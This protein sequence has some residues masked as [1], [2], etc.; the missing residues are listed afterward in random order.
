MD[1]GE[2]VTGR[3]VLRGRIGLGIA[4]AAGI[5][6]LAGCESS[7]EKA[8]KHYES[9]LALL[10][11]GDV[12]RAMVEFRNVFS[13]DGNHQEARQTYARLLREQGS[14]REA[15]SQYLRLVEQY[16]DNAE[17]NRALAEMAL[18][19]SNWDDADRYG[20]AALRL[21]PDEPEVQGIGAMIDY[22]AALMSRDEAAGQA[23]LQRAQALVGQ[24]PELVVA[25]RVTL[26]SLVRKSD[27]EAVLAS[28]DEGLQHDPNSFEFQRMRAAALFQLGRTDDLEAQLRQMAL[29]NPEDTEIENSLLGLFINQKRP[30]AAEEFLRSRV[31]PASADPAA[32]QRLVSFIAQTRGMPAARQEID[33][34]VAGNPPKVGIYRTMRAGIDFDAGNRDG[35]MAEMQSIIDSKPEPDVL[36]QARVTL[37]R[38]MAQ[39]GNKVGGRALVEEVLASTPSDVDALKLKGNWLIDDDRTGDA[40][41]ALRS[42]LEYAPRDPQ[43]MTLMARAHERDG[44]RDLMGEMLSQA[45]VAS[46]R[47]PSES[48]RYAAFLEQDGKHLPAEDALVNALRLQPR[49][50]DLL[51][52]LGRVYVA[53]KDWPRADHVVRTLKE[54]GTDQAV[55]SANEITANRLAALNQDQELAAFL[56][57][58][59]AEGDSGPG[60]ELALIRTSLLR[61]DT[62][63]ALRQADALL[64]KTPDNP[65]ALYLHAAVLLS[66]GQKEGLD[67][68]RALTQS[69]P[70][71]EMGWAALHNALLSTGDTEGAGKVLQ[72][73]LAAIPT[74]PTLSWIKAGILEKS[75][76]IDGAITLYEAMYER[77][78]NSPIIA[79]NLASL[80]AGYRSDD[81]S[82]DRAYT[83][84]RRLRGTTVPAFQDTY[85]WI[86]YRRG[87][88][89]EAL[90]NLEPAAQG[91]PQDGTVQ[92]HLA[93]TYS[94]LGRKDEAKQLLLRLDEGAIPLPAD[95]ADRVKAELARLA[96]PDAPV[97]STPEARN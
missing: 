54:I 97:V 62:Q 24:H 45:V 58:L 92:Y 36:N 8:Q 66:A 27:W 44:S 17:G 33:R 89:D 34:I 75:G 29:A 21:A 6:L 38:M 68:M 18:D 9:G 3:K 13:L 74:A 5:G 43:I 65:T 64:A 76:D 70:G 41:V 59:A 1:E 79:N 80:L 88:F 11:Q 53:M 32:R 84:A 19:A 78:S 94:A 77:D 23:A 67:E 46:S 20:R 40:L 60:V 4:L 63:E 83:V 71:F 51:S 39:V 56:R 15:Y 81:A 42:A 12:S 37:A 61:G 26:D 28:L 49:N 30:E 90:S 16:P 52:A 91:L 50:V 55:N 22:R 69:H 96:P 2:D 73:G 31:D 47:A 7:E 57:G 14:V 93:M 86:A 87:N 25:R 82:L 10:E 95:Y 35:A 48:L 72:A 85:G